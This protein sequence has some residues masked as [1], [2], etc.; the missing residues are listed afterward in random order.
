MPF[1][2]IVF[3]R[4]ASMPHA[5]QVIMLRRAEP[6]AA[7]MMVLMLLLQLFCC[8]IDGA[9]SA[10]VSRATPTCQYSSACSY[11][12]LTLAVFVPC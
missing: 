11:V 7:A 8:G 3:G 1:E 9:T 5:E 10:T 4:S 6:A 12:C 2:L